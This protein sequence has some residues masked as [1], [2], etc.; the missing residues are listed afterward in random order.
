MRMLSRLAAVFLS[1]SCVCYAVTACNPPESEEAAPAASGP[2]LEA[3]PAPVPD[4]TSPPVEE[5][6]AAPPAEDAGVTSPPA[7]AAPDVVADSSVGVDSS[8][9]VPDAAVPPPVEAG[10]DAAPEAGVD[11]GLPCVSYVRPPVTP[12]WQGRAY[13]AL[14]LSTMSIPFQCATVTENNSCKFTLC[15][16]GDDC[17]RYPAPGACRIQVPAKCLACTGGQT[18]W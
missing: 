9:P 14:P 11:S 15:P 13:Y 16:A 10:V 6:A 18:E 17:K 8:V 12:Y 3:A 5:D 1:G 7:D 2:E 4:G